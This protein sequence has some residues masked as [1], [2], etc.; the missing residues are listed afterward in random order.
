MYMA[1]EEFY[2]FDLKKLDKNYT[3]FYWVKKQFKNIEVRDDLKHQ[4]QWDNTC[5]YRIVGYNFSVNESQTCAIT[6]EA[7]KHY[8]IDKIVFLQKIID[9]IEQSYADIDCC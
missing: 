7:W 4:K 9:R 3:L 6:Q 2:Q 1:D 8:I 5:L